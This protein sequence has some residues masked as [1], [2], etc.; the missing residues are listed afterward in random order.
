M[1]E[2]NNAYYEVV[3]SRSIRLQNGICEDITED[4]AGEHIA[5]LQGSDIFTESMTPTDIELYSYSPYPCDAVMVIK[6]KD[7]Y[8]VA[9]FCN[10][11]SVT[12]DGNVNMKVS[13]LY[14][15]YGIY[16]ASD[17]IAISE[18]AVGKESWSNRVTD[19]A[20]IN[21]FYDIT[22]SLESYNNSGY[23]Y[24]LFN[25]KSEEEQQEIS[26]CMADSMR[27][28]YIHTSGGLKLTLHLYPEHGWLYAS[29]T[30]Y[31]MSDEALE[32]YSENLE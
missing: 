28:L 22:L 18:A 1:I 12:A 7:K 19:R 13:E 10:Y 4:T 26:I 21:A 9:V 17:I 31:K 15:L 25:G 8:S 3:D 11:I 27:Y 32:W 16:S 29:L 2:Y 14:R 20:V 30:S 6:E 23:Q 5:Y 24:A